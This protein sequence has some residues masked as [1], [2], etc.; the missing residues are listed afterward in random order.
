MF[1]KVGADGRMLCE[2]LAHKG[3]NLSVSGQSRHIDFKELTCSTAIIYG[4]TG[5]TCDLMDH[6]ATSGGKVGCDPVRSCRAISQTGL[7]VTCENDGVS[8]RIDGGFT[9]GCGGIHDVSRVNVEGRGSRI[10]RG[11][12]RSAGSSFRLMHNE[13]IDANHPGGFALC[14]QR[15]PTCHRH[16]VQ[17][18]LENE[19]EQWSDDAF[20]NELPRRLPDALAEAM[21]TGPSIAPLRS[22]VV[23][24]LR[25]RFLVLVGDTCHIAPPTLA[26]T[27]CVAASD[28][29]CRIERLSKLHRDRSFARIDGYWRRRRRWP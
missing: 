1:D 21:V 8:Q 24:L 22:Y 10:S 3:Y 6:H 17:V 7:F 2:G 14:S 4:K 27:L 12:I 18:P 16:Y 5:L 25:F 13:R 29:D 9:A 11:S 23:E 26:S 28:L 20:G 15:T 19:V